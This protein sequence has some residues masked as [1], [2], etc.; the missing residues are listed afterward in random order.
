MGWQV[1]QLIEVI[2][3]DPMLLVLKLVERLHRNEWIKNQLKKNK[4]PSS[5]LFSLVSHSQF[6]HLS[7]CYSFLLAYLE[8][9]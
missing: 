9:E 5:T 4:T 8:N 3:A 1:E 7:A 2:G 6:Y